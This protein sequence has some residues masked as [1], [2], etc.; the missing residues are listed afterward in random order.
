MTERMLTESEWQRNVGTQSYPVSFLH[1]YAVGLIWDLLHL[2]KGPV[3]L[4]NIDG[5]TI[6]DVMDGIDQVII[7]DALQ[8]IA[9]FIPDISLLNSSRPIR[10]IEVIVTNPVK[11]DKRQA[12]TNLG[13]EL[14][15]VPVRDENDLRAL[16]PTSPSDKSYWWPKFSS[17]ERVF[18]EA[19]AKTGV[20]WRGTRQYKIL[21][22]QEKADKVINDLIGA[23]SRCSPQV[24][25]SFLT[26]LQSITSLESLYPLRKE[27]PKY[28]CLQSEQ[29]A[30]QPGK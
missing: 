2:N 6:E 24:R 17:S 3:P 1:E 19:R 4:P 7:P 11:Q 21:D 8:S 23:L 28:A 27:N 26:R 25:R 30:E 18:S 16:C 9:G 13:V 5:N 10:C 12:I 22:E 14:I 20:N 15:Q 29:E